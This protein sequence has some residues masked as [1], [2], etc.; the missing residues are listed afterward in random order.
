[1]SL[2][3][4]KLSKSVYSDLDEKFDDYPIV[5]QEQFRQLMGGESIID[6]RG[7]VL[8]EDDGP[9]RVMSEEESES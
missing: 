3:I 6:E 8:T 9:F 2:R 4:D 1:M 7:R 5:S